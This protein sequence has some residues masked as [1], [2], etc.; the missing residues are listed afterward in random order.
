M[1]YYV[2]AASG[3]PSNRYN[4]TFLKASQFVETDEAYKR[5]CNPGQK[6]LG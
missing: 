1:T 5:K 4:T 6:N 2:P 3:S